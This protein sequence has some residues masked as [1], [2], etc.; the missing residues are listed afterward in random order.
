[1]CNLYSMTT[2]VQAIRDFVRT[3]RE[4]RQNAN[5]GNFAPMPDIF[6]DQFAPIVRNTDA[7][8]ELA[9]VR[10]GM[11]SSSR[12]LFE[13]AKARAQ[14][15]Q[16]K[17]GRHLSTD[18]FNELVAM[19]PDRGTTNIRN[20][21]SRHWERWLAP[22]FRCVV[23]FNSF[24]EFKKEEGGDIWFA[25]DDSRPLA[26]FAGIWAPQWESVRKIKEGKV[27]TDLFAF[28]T[29]DANAEVKPIHPKAMPVILRTPEEVQIWMTAPWEEARK[30][31]RPLPDGLLK[32]VSR[33][34]KEDPPP[35]DSAEPPPPDQPSLF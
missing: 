6:P 3:G 17:Q 1:M 13:A 4:L 21:G 16:T 5:L 24:S 11:P 22:R 26:I 33:G 23:P 7:G 10:W 20:T 2:N 15:I 29:T 27:V 28:L 30:L 25:F 35:S 19:E 9:M 18:E 14:K 32:I 34:F 8:P 12:A 31:Q